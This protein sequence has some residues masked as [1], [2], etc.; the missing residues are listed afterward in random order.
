MCHHHNFLQNNCYI[1][2]FDFK[3][4]ISVKLP[5][6]YNQFKVVVISDGNS[7]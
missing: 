1:Q 2:A 7:I 6:K 5:N 3:P 4:T